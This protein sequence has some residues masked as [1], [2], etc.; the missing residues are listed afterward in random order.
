MFC[1]VN[2]FNSKEPKEIILEDDR[3]GDCDFCGS[4]GVSIIDPIDL[5]ELFEPLLDY[6]EVVEY[7]T[8][9]FDPDDD[10]LDYGEPLG[11]L[12]QS[13]W[14]I[15]S[16]TIGSTEKCNELIE[17]IFEETI[18]ANDLW[19]TIDDRWYVEPDKDRSIWN[20]L[21]WYLKN[22]RRFFLDFKELG[23][24]DLFDRLEVYILEQVE[25]ILPK[26]S[27]LFRTRLGGNVI[28]ED[29]I[30]PF[31]KENMGAP[32]ASPYQQGRGN[33]PGVSYLYAAS[34]EVTAIGEKR[35]GRNSILSLGELETT[36]E[37]RLINLAN[38]P[39]LDSP[40][41]IE[42][43]ADEIRA[44]SILMFLG[45]E[46][47]RPVSIE[48]P[49]N[50]YLPSQFLCEFILKNSYDGVIYNSSYGTGQNYLLF[51]TKS[52]DIKNVNLVEVDVQFSIMASG[53]VY[54]I[55]E[56]RLD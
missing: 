19:C 55:K 50:E 54:N 5:R 7:K 53:I 9:Y 1:C 14:E 43:L 8:H 48:D 12:L 25:I 34:D 27:T 35:P 46:L 2:C 4:T 41:R 56:E 23:A 31:S 45:K 10:P 44:R 16:D 18:D 40:F 3:I 21:S 15:F 29:E 42:Y 47:S 49:P 37:L 32:P 22:K 38:V 36:R 11:Y 33:P 28:S 52:A 39:Y 6:Y 20:K 17:A 30:R 51:D 24:D 13:H 26:G